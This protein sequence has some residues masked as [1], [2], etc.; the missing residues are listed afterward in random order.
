LR[1]WTLLLIPHDTDEPRS[2]AV[3]ERWLR[4]GAAGVVV[5]L[6]AAVVGIGTIAARWA[7]VDG[8]STRARS[9]GVLGDGSAGATAS[10]GE[11]D[12][13]RATVEALYQVLDTI[14]QSDAQLSEAAG[15]GATGASAEANHAS[16]ALTRASADSLLQGASQVAER[17][18]AL[19]DSAR[20]RR[21]PAVKAQSPEHPASPA[22]KH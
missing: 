3:S 11:L 22:T 14:R 20:R 2:I 13:L 6:F 9:A 21:E 5:I 7:S 1:S 18:V 19:A 8:P 4:V 12:S 15:L 17:L 16:I 10:G